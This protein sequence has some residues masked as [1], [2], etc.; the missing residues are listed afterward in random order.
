MEP[1]AV[2]KFK[3][4]LPGAAHR[5]SNQSPVLIG[6][7][8]AK[9]QVGAGS[10]NQPI[11]DPLDRRL[12]PQRGAGVDGSFNWTRDLAKSSS[13]FVPYHLHHAGIFLGALHDDRAKAMECLL[14]NY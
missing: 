9:A 11:D 10:R 4:G 12:G 7:A 8:F 6:A 1:W 14:V 3:Q 5:Q 13:G 2:L